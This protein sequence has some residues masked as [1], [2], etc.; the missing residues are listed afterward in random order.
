MSRRTGGAWLAELYGTGVTP[1]S[2]VPDASIGRIDDPEDSAPAPSVELVEGS[3]LAVHPVAAASPPGVVFFLD[4]IQQW[5]V[6]GHDGV[7][8][9]AIAHVAAAARRRGR[10]RHLR[11]TDVAERTLLLAQLVGMPDARRQVL[12]ASGYDVVALPDEATG[13]PGVVLEAARREVHRARATLEKTIAE[14]VAGRLGDDEWL[15]VDGQLAVSPRLA[16]HPRV[17][18][19]IKSHGAQFLDGR[20]LERALTVPAAHRT[21]LFRVLGGH[22]RT[23]VESWYLRLWPW[24]GHDLFY[25][26]L[27]IE[28]RA[29]PATPAQAD[30]ISG[31]LLGERAPLATPDA[32]FDRLLYPIHQVEEYLKARAPRGGGLLRPHVSRLPK[33]GS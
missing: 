8:P 18:G 22:G 3:D 6:I 7:S 11:T 13:Q 12:A 26:L 33:T 24:E 20:H 28:A 15:V 4:G 19:V 9:I 5:R 16:R 23:A 27:R 2:F 29:D 10:D 21:G 17:L 1:A 32:R 25:G 14:Q 31:W 30:A